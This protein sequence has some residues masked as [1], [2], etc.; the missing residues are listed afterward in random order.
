MHSLKI[1]GPLPFSLIQGFV[2]EICTPSR[3]L[4][5]FMN[6]HTSHYCPDTLFLDGESGILIFTLPQNTTH[7]IRPLDK[8]VFGSFK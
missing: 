5:L 1:G 8:E 7:L 4:I 6:G 3:P 2:H